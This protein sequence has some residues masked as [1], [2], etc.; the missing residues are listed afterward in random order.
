MLANLTAIHDTSRAF[1]V[2]A[3]RNEQPSGDNALRLVSADIWFGAYPSGD[4][5]QVTLRQL[6]FHVVD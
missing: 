4:A 1:A 3:Y 6:S 5:A 2:L